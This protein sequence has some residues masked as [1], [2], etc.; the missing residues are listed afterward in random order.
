MKTATHRHIKTEVVKFKVGKDFLGKVQYT[1]K[2]K[3]GST[4]TMS[5]KNFAETFVENK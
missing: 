5:E 1:V 4:T 3:D 2:F